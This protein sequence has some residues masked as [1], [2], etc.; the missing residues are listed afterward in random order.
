MLSRRKM[1]ACRVNGKERRVL[2]VEFF[3]HCIFSLLG[4]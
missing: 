3:V 1:Y 2:S 4:G